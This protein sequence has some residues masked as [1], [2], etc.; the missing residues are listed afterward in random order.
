MLARYLT[1]S[2]PQAIRAKGF[3]YHRMGAVVAISGGEWAAHAVVRG[4]RN[5]RVE[6][7]RDRDLFRASCDC[8]YFTDRAQ[9]C[10]HVWAAIIEA[11]ERSLLSGSGELTSD[12]FL[13]PDVSRASTRKRPNVPMPLQRAQPPPWQRFLTDL[14]QRT[15]RSGAPPPAQEERRLGQAEA[16]SGIG[17]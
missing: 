8:A 11:D 4:G 10:K 3:R 15:R 6:I 2:V 7:V 13:E 5:Y 17:A 1:S 9:I 12:A 14:N 16:G